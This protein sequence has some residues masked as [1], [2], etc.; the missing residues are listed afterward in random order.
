MSG[1]RPGTHGEVGQMIT[2]V[3]STAGHRF[4]T[5]YDTE[6][7]CLTCGAVYVL[8]PDDVDPT[9]GRYETLTGDPIEWCSGDT[10]KLHGYERWC[11]NC[12]SE[13]CSHATAPC[14]CHRCN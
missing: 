8:A 13:E 1:I 6:E 12:E 14:D 5:E 2:S 7:I 3:D 9:H 10:T 4:I 11:T